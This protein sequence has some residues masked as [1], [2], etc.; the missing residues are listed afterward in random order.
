M[1]YIVAEKKE[2]FFFGIKEVKGYEREKFIIS[3]RSCRLI[4]IPDLHFTYFSSVFNFNYAHSRLIYSC[5]H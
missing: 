1:R 3:K 2:F 5:F 4:L